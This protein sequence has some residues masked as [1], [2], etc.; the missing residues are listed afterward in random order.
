MYCTVHVYRLKNNVNHYNCTVNIYMVFF[1]D[2][3]EISFTWGYILGYINVPELGQVQTNAAR[4]NVLI[5]ANLHLN[6][7]Q[8]WVV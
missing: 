7:K 8:Y 4:L 1:T 2:L 6:L 3:F 5:G